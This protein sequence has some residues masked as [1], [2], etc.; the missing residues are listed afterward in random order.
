M[1]PLLPAKPPALG[2][3]PPRPILPQKPQ[4]GSKLPGPVSDVLRKLESLLNPGETVEDFAASLKARAEQELGKCRAWSDLGMA[5]CRDLANAN[6]GRRFLEEVLN[7][8]H[9]KQLDAR[10]A[11]TRTNDVF[12]QNALANAKAKSPFGDGVTIAIG[13]GAALGCALGYEKCYGLAMTGFLAT[14]RAFECWSRT[15][16]AGTVEASV[17]GSIEFSLGA[18]SPKQPDFLAKSPFG[19]KAPGWDGWGLGWS[20]GGGWGA[21][22]GVAVAF[23]PQWLEPVATWKFKGLAVQFGGGGGADL[24]MWVQGATARELPALP[25]K[26]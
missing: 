4:L 23:A 21:T 19:A 6:R 22:L 12:G 18:P 7:P 8:M 26:A 24:G 16:H 2:L 20:F 11:V 5:L 15:L 9:K 1:K 10:S 14:P 3:K 17:S 13:M 25:A